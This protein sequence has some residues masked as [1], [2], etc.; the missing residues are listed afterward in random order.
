MVRRASHPGGRG[1]AGKS[2]GYVNDGAYWAFVKYPRLRGLDTA[3]RARFC[4]VVC[5]RGDAGVRRGTPAC[6]GTPSYGKIMEDPA[7]VE[8][9][10]PDRGCRVTPECPGSR[11]SGS[12]LRAHMP[13]PPDRDREPAAPPTRDRGSLGSYFDGN[14]PRSCQSGPGIP[15][16][17]PVP[18]REYSGVAGGARV[19]RGHRG[20]ARRGRRVGGRLCGGA[21]RAPRPGPGP[22]RIAVRHPR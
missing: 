5:S 20:R 11:K 7:S 9:P 6:G 16:L 8:D 19:I 14:D 12:G 18:G 17:L 13:G 10:V 22:R 21:D 2:L 4:L 3:L 1:H 15:V